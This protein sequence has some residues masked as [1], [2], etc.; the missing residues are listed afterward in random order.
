MAVDNVNRPKVVKLGGAREERYAY[1]DAATIVAGD[2]IRLSTA[3]SIE[4]ATASGAGAVHGMALY[5]GTTAGDILPVLMFSDDTIVELS[6][7]DTVVPSTTLKKG[8]E[9]TLEIG[10]NEFGVTSTTTAGIALL[11]DYADTSTPWHDATGVFGTNTDTA[12]SAKAGGSVLVR[13]SAATL[14][15]TASA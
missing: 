4:V 10:T 13:F 11:V 14:A 3:G 5:A 7:I 6:A 8:E 12:A 1:A 9:Y 15:G 2:L